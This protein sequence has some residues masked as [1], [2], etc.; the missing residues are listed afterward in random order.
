[1]DPKSLL[2]VA[3]ILNDA[4][5][6]TVFGVSFLVSFLVVRFRRMVRSAAP[7]PEADRAND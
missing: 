5:L 3:D 4:S 6:L 2:A 7:S 1:M